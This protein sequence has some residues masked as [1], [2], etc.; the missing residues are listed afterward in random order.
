M[1]KTK[2]PIID[3]KYRKCSKCKEI[4]L[5]D[6]FAK[7]NSISI[8]LRPD[9]KVCKHN[10]YFENKQK[11][12][13]TRRKYVAENKDKINETKRKY[14]KN[15][16]DKIRKCARSFYEK[17]KEKISIN[18]KKWRKESVSEQFYTYQVAAKSRGLEFLLT[19]EQFADEIQKPCF[20][21]GTVK[22]KRGID[23]YDNNKG[24]M[25]ENCVSCC[26]PC[27]WMK[28][29]SNVDHFLAHCYNIVKHSKL[30]IERNCASGP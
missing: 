2:N 29:N 5:I 8:G 10:Y 27:N 7:N 22:I 28:R 26:Y 21:C 30:R 4:K 20:Y 17:N 1:R 15:N 9:C 11:F 6:Q 13:K 3:G 16:K 18:N 19:K 14:Y 23:R 24:Y 25:L 12:L